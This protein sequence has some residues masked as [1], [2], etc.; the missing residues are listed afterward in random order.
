MFEILLAA[1]VV[2][3]IAATAIVFR[4]DYLERPQALMHTLIAWLIPFLGAAFVMVFQWTIHKD[5]TTRS[6]PDNYNPNS[7]D[8]ESDALYHELDSSD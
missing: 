3:A 5:M 6:G 4:L 2:L 8:I 7:K 1:Y